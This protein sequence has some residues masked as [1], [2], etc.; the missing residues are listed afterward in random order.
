MEKEKRRKK[1][2]VEVEFKVE[3]VVYLSQIER[4]KKVE[5]PHGS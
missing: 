1:F 4:G 2:R 3:L 5:M